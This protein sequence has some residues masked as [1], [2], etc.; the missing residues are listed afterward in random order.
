MTDRTKISYSQGMRCIEP[1]TAVM[2]FEGLMGK[3]MLALRVSSHVFQL[4][5]KWSLERNNIIDSIETCN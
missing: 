4:A 2:I 3:K 1:D 5:V